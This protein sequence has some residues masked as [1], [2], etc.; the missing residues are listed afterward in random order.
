M[1]P[2]NYGEIIEK[3]EARRVALEAITPKLQAIYDLWDTLYAAARPINSVNADFEQL[4]SEAAALLAQ[5]VGVS[6]STLG[7]GLHYLANVM[8]ML[9]RPSKDLLEALKPNEEA[10]LE[11]IGAGGVSGPLMGRASPPTA[12]AEGWRPIETAPKDCQAILVTEG[13][14]CHCVEWN[15]EFDWWAVDDNKLGPFRLRGSSP[16][17]WMPLPP[18]PTSAEG[19]EH[20]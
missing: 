17:H 9:D 11:A 6:V 12:Q 19:V 18:P 13:R 8:Q 4:D 5:S 2:I 7:C 14:F 1:K 16:T 10:Q 20:G 15:E 3:A